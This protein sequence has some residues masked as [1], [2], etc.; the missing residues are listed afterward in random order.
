MPALAFA[1][2]FA[3]GLVIISMRSSA[4]AGRLSRPFWEP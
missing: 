4:D 2:N 1:S 3:E